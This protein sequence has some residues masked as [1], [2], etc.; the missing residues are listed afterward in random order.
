MS[1]WEQNNLIAHI[2]FYLS[3]CYLQSN[4]IW[5]SLSGRCNLSQRS[6]IRSLNT[7]VVWPSGTVT[8][9]LVY[10]CTTILSS[11]HFC[12]CNLYQPLL[13]S[14]LALYVT[15]VFLCVLATYL[16][17]NTSYLFLNHNFIFIS[18]L[19]L[20]PISTMTIFVSCILFYICISLRLCNISPSRDVVFILAPQFYLHFIFAAATYL[21]HY[22]LAFYFTSVFL[23]VFATYLHHETSS[24]FLHHNFISFLPLQPI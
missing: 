21:N 10:S 19:L 11:F 15:S 1:S 9:R 7:V 18:F 13:F 22:S 24:L 6:I 14:C 4:F 23:Y 3:I 5:I 17:H 12:C 8:T 20:Q 2:A 16:H